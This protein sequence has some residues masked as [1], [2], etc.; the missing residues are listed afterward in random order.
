[1]SKALDRAVERCN[2]GVRLVVLE[3][4]YRPELNGTVRTITK[5]NPLSRRVF[6]CTSSSYP[7]HEFAMELAKTGLGW[8]DDDTICYPTGREDQSWPAAHG[9]ASVPAVC[10]AAALRRK[11]S[12][13]TSSIVLWTRRK[14]N[15]TR[16]GLLHGPHVAHVVG[17][18]CRGL[19]RLT[20][21][22]P[23]S[24]A[25]WSR[26]AAFSALRRRSSS[27]SASS[28]RWSDSIEAR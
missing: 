17:R 10:Q 9:H 3:S 15:L 7:S 1:M 5:L 13:A 14:K 6:G 25:T 20:R 26:R 22:S 24:L 4:T 11:P 19:L 28:R 2:L 12:R 8:L 18:T 23:N 21:C 27:W 16:S